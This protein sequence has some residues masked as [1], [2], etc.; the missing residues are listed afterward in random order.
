M[1][2]AVIHTTIDPK[3]KED[4]LAILSKLGLKQADAINLFFSQIV[5]RKGL[6]FDVTIPAAETQTAI[7]DVDS[8][9]K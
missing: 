6:P 7:D 1:K 4:A 5:L 2:R 9:L 3:L 8:S